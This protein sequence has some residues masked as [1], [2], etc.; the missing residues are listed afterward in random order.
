VDT[1]DVG[2]G[3]KCALDRLGAGKT[4]ELGVEGLGDRRCVIAV[5]SMGRVRRVGRHGTSRSCADE[6]A[7]ASQRLGIPADDDE[8]VCCDTGIGVMALIPPDGAVVR[9][10]GVPA[11]CGRVVALVGLT[12]LVV[13]GAACAGDD[14]RS[15]GGRGAAAD[16]GIVHVHGLGVNPTDGAL[17]AATH[18]G[19][20]RIPDQGKAERIA[21]RHQDTMGFT[22]A[23]PD[24]FLGSGHPDMQEYRAGRLP[25]LLGLIESRDAGRTWQP[26]S[27]LG[28]ADFHALRAVHGRIYGYDSSGAALLVSADGRTWETRAAQLQLVDFAV[29]PVDPELLVATTPRGTLRSRD[30]GRNWEPLAAPALTL[31]A[32]PDEAVLWGV[33]AAGALFRS[34]DGGASWQQAGALAGQPEALLA[35]GGRLYAAVHGGGIA[36]SDDGGRTWR[37]R[38]REPSR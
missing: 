5:M 24:H 30:G 16:A 10:D 20:F 8:L 25:A 32:W 2:I 22:V 36:L 7:V 6:D 38:Y 12:A 14:G 13:L 26:L 11:L 27:L 23:G 19:L 18:T 37:V 17:F 9:P 1:D 29:S 15:S 21:D 33:T 31:L 3:A 35:D 34:G 4:G 28:Q